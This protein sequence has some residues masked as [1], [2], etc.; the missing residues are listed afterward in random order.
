MGLMGTIVVSKKEIRTMKKVEDHALITHQE[1]GNAFEGIYYVESAFIKQT[2]NKKDF[3][4]MVLRDKS[5]GRN[6]KYWGVVDGVEKGCFV[7]I[8]ANVDSYQNNPSII[9]K[10]VEK[11]EEPE[12]MSNYLPVYS[13][14]GTVSNATRFDE[15]R[16]ALREIEEKTGNCVAGTLVDEA[17]SNPSTFAKFVTSPGNDKPHYGCQGGLLANT[18]RVA[19]ACIWE[20]TSQKLT[21]MEMSVLIASA[22][23]SRIGSVE[24][25]EFQ[26]CMPTATKKGIL[27]GVTN[28]TMNRIYVAIKRMVES[29]KKA[30]KSIDTE[31]IIRILH[32]VATHEGNSG[33]KPMTKEAMI[34]NSAYTHDAQIVNAVDFIDADVNLSEEFT[35]YDPVNGRKYYT[36]VRG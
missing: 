31:T 5:G 24:A 21:D 10:N 29:L 28:L 7:Y 4:D 27:L 15:I 6:V 20:G 33:I 17:Y 36:G 34:L 30:G 32:A 18:V 23:L 1:I 13:E 26:N 22:L 14:E 11:V 3:T 25:F 9:A 16:Q 8:S 19:E 12:D 35:A 2:V